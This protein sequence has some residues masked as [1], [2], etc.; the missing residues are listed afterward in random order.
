MKKPNEKVLFLLTSF[1]FP[2]LILLSPKILSL[3]GIG[4]CW[5]VLWLLPW[6][7]A[8]GRTFGIFSGLCLGLFLDGISMS[9]ASH[10]PAMIFL[11]FW[12][13]QIGSQGKKIDLIFNLGLL[14]L[15]GAIIFGFSLWIQIYFLDGHIWSDWFNSWAFH[16]VLAQ[17]ILTGLI[18]PATC[19]WILLAKRNM[20]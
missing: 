10:I 7:L 13:G 17:S 2:C 16:T 15:I 1:C 3:Q 18:A 12:W 8:K 11:G 14:A 6:S 5:S 19:S 4:P 9:G 20:K